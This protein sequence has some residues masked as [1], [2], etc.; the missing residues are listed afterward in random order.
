[1]KCFPSQKL[2]MTALIKWNKLFCVHLWQAMNT[3]NL[4]TEDLKVLP[5][6]NK[7]PTN[8]L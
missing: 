7:L 8:M 2:R 4:L 6:E 1:M 3:Y 5:Q